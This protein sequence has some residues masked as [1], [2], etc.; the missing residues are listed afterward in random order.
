MVHTLACARAS[1]HARTHPQRQNHA[2]THRTPPFATP[3]YIHD[4]RIWIHNTN[5]HK[6][7]RQVL[8]PDGGLPYI[9]RIE[10]LFEF[11]EG[12]QPQQ[13]TQ[14]ESCSESP[15]QKQ[16]CVC[17][18]C[19]CECVHIHITRS[20]SV[21]QQQK[22]RRSCGGTTGPVTARETKARRAS[23]MPASHKP[24][25]CLPQHGQTRIQ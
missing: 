25:R 14:D 5:T 6:H 10:A 20:L 12:E 19:V 23:R 11:V 24:R 17:A 9:A 2:R 4:A 15:D 21:F 13:G 22:S 18:C 16:V 1:T 7:T 8:S 3:Q